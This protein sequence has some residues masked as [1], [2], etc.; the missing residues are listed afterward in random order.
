MKKFYDNIAII[1]EWLVNYAGSERCVE[2][3]VNIWNESDVYALVDFLND[4]DRKQ[5]LK[6]KN[7]KTTFIQ[8][9][10]FAKTKHRS[11][12]PFFPLAIEQLDLTKYNI[13]LSSSHS[14][15]KGVLVKSNQLHICYC[16]TPM[17]YAWDSYF[18][19]LKE[20]NLTNGLKEFIVKL[21]LH[22]LR[23]WDLSTTNRVDYFIANSKYIAQ[24]IRKI[25]HRDAEV[26][27]PPV[28]IDKFECETKKENY[29]LTASRFVPYKKVDIIVEAFSKM[30]DKKLIVIGDGPEE[31]RI[32]K[33]ATKNIE[34]LKFQEQ[35][36]L[37]KYFQKAKA[38]VFAAEEDFGITLVEA[39]SCGTPV[40]AFNKGGAAETIINYEN[41]IHFNE[42]TSDAIIDAIK[43]FEITENHF[44][45]IKIS[46]GTKKF[47][48][49][50]FE[51]KIK[52]FVNLKAE[53]F[54]NR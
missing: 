30:P 15:A 47:S 6:G 37:K 28:D 8:K 44:D 54:F 51:Q 43:K 14:V 39:L 3:F 22:Y 52:E 40:I 53:E 19:Y 10:P 26:I 17:R 16:H 25:Y 27:Y 50:I 38:F 18:Q 46:E 45:L 23:I 36:E 42:Q 34:F 7:A 33:I 4:E 12:L 5:I 31:N 35:E 20:A 41:G 49:N 2:S 11:Y 9:L 29:Y 21:T 32:K 13:I 24:R 48:R 1:H